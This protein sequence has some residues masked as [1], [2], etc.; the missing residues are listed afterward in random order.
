MTP[1]HPARYQALGCPTP[2][3]PPTTFPHPAP[4]LVNGPVSRRLLAAASFLPPAGSQLQSAP[5]DDGPGPGIV[6]QVG[7]RSQDGLYLTISRSTQTC[8][9]RTVSVSGD[10]TDRVSITPLPDGGQ[11]V[12]ITSVQPGPALYASLQEP[13]GQRLSIGETPDRYTPDQLT[14]ALIRIRGNLEERTPGP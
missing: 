2:S 14:A 10:P 11:V 5:E 3:A 9:T 12:V 6:G 13:D 4:A 8:R 1:G 7:W